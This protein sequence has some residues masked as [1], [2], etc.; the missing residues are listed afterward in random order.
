[1]VKHHLDLSQFHQAIAAAKQRFALIQKKHPSL[2]GYLV[3]SLPGGQAPLH[4]SLRQIIDEF[5]PLMPD[6][7]PKTRMLDFLSVPQPEKPTELQ[8]KQWKEEFEELAEQLEFDGRVQLEIRFHN[9]DYGLIWKLQS[10][11]LVD[12]DLTPRT[13]ASIRIV[14]GKLSGF[15]DGQL[16]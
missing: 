16:R 8:L 15:A 2:R 4:S 3:L 11:E 6:G 7:E 9:L 12:R 5:Q 1:M 14:L 10:D 13:K